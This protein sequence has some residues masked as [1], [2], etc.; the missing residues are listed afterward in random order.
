MKYYLIHNLEESRRDRMLQ[1]F[2]KGDIPEE[3]V[4]WIL[5]PNKNDITEDLRAQWVMQEPST[6]CNVPVEAGCPQLR[7]GQIACAYKHYL[8]LK[9]IVE[10]GLEYAVIMEDNMQFNTNISERLDIYISQLNELY[11]DWDILFDLNWMRYIEGETRE[12][13]YV[14]PKSNEIGPNNCHGGGKC[15]QFYLLNQK[16]AKK[17]YKNYIP[18]NSPPDWWMNDLFRKLDIRSFWA[19]PGAVDL[20]SHT[21]T[22]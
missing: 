22:V 9:D 11:P 10:K 20:Y 3:D 15:A 2:K 13:W 14:Y 19:E 21:S 7:P 4:T 6:T 1:E 17:L 16:C 5:Y 12:G 18:F 8:A